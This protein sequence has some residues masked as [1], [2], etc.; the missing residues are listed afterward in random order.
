ML[1]LLLILIVGPLVVGGITLMVLLFIDN[2]YAKKQRKYLNNKMISYSLYDQALQ[3]QAR[4]EKRFV[5]VK[6]KNEW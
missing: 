2:S 4:G 3:K 6:C 1:N 5:I